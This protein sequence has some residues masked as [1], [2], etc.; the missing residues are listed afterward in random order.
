VVLGTANGFIFALDGTTGED[1]TNFPFRRAPC[2][3]ARAFQGRGW[4]RRSNGSAAARPQ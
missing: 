2:W 4:S 3:G 1:I